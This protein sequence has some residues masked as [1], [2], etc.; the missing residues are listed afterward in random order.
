MRLAAL[1][2]VAAALGMSAVQLHAAEARAHAG[3][4]T[5]ITVQNACSPVL[6]DRLG[7][8][9]SVGASGEGV[10][11]IKGWERH[12]DWDDDEAPRSSSPS[13]GTRSGRSDFAGRKASTT[14]R[15]SWMCS[16][17]TEAR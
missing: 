11:S 13:S 5:S 16:A 15:S 10:S 12:E 7:R 6:I 9:D 2:V 17:R 4:T 3:V 14:S 1:V 8:R